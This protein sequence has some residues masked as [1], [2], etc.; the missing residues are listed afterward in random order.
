MKKAVI[1]VFVAVLTIIGCKQNAADD[2][3]EREGE[4]DIYQ[5]EKEDASMKAAIEKARATISQFDSALNANNKNFEDFAIKQSFNTDVEDGGEHIWI[6][7]I[8][9]RN[10]DYYGIVNNEPEW[11]KEVKLGQQVKVDKSR[12]SDWMYLDNGRLKGGYSIVVLRNKMSKKEKKNFD[13][14]SG[15]II[16]D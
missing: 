14:Q 12:I 13:A 3:V 4:P 5:V 2:K 6:G 16:E 15:M 11:T 1:A 7:D 9:I 10:G 8:S